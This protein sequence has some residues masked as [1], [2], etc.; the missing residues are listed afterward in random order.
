MYNYGRIFVA[1]DIIES[2][3]LHYLQKK[4]VLQTRSNVLR[5]NLRSWQWSSELRPSRK[6]QHPVVLHK[7]IFGKSFYL[8]L[9]MSIIY[10]F[11]FFHLCYRKLHNMSAQSSDGRSGGEGKSNEVVCASRPCETSSRSAGCRDDEKCD[12]AGSSFIVEDLQLYVEKSTKHSSSPP[13]CHCFKALEMSR[14]K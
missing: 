10:S 5:W 4:R 9:R 6:K 7:R 1:C 3:G 14:L 11:L 13:D 8:F 2:L 12:E